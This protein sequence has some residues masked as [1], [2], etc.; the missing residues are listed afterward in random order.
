MHAAHS[1]KQTDPPP[2]TARGAPRLLGS[3]ACH[4]LCGFTPE[5][6]AAV[7]TL[8][9]HATSREVPPAPVPT[10]SV[11]ACDASLA[12]RARALPLPPHKHEP[13]RLG[14]QDPR[15]PSCC[16]TLVIGAVPRSSFGGRA[17]LR[18]PTAQCALAVDAIRRT[19]MGGRGR[20]SHGRGRA[21]CSAFSPTRTQ[22]VAVHTAIAKA[23]ADASVFN[24]PASARARR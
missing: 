3:T 10:R 21:P 16:P 22:G 18:H 19:R 13:P 9:T 14:F 23:G 17:Q 2:H 6:G 20:E 24:R 12:P 8:T 11:H 4:H 15:A 5:A 1:S 7:A